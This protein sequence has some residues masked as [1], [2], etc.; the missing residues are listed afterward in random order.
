M[1]EIK[2]DRS[3][4]LPSTLDRGERPEIW[5]DS[6]VKE[7]SIM[8]NCNICIHY[9]VCAIKNKIIPWITIMLNCDPE[10]AC[11]FIAKHC[12]QYVKAMHKKEQTCKK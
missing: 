4:F 5:K 6:T 12:K 1:Q 9:E 3:K 11:K 8:K 2:H 10:K 7:S